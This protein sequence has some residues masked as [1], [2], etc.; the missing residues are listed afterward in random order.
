MQT[1]IQS[2]THTVTTGSPAKDIGMVMMVSMDVHFGVHSV[3]YI[4]VLPR[5]Q[6]PGRYNCTTVDGRTISN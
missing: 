2:G 3:N 5:C 1:L 6:G 4:F